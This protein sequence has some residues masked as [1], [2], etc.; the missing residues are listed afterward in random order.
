MILDLSKPAHEAAATR[1]K[2]ETIIWLTTVNPKG[3]P[4][5]SPVWFLWDGEEF[6][7]YGSKTGPK[8]PS[9][10][11]NPRVGLNLDGNGRGGG[12]VVIE[13][14]ARIDEAGPALSEVNDYLAKYGA[15]IEGNGWTPET[16]AQDYPHLIRVTPNKA[17]IW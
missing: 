3:Q 8:T 7:I 2:E 14:T 10:R 13:G 5:S 1:L 4:Q 15:M 6:L 12:I 9:I 16:M 17:R 11:S